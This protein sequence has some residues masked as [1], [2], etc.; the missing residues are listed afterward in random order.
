MQLAAFGETTIQFIGFGSA[1]S[2]VARIGLLTTA[3]STP[4]SSLYELS[5]WQT[6]Q[7]MPTP[8][9]ATSAA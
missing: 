1:F 9:Q 4:R 6:L 2:V 7:L 8:G 5:T 3:P